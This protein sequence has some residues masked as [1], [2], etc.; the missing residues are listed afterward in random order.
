[1]NNKINIVLFGIGNVGSA[2]INK[3]LKNRKRLVL[4]KQIDF[5]FP[6]ITNSS[7]AF[8]AKEGTNFSWEANFIQF[9]IPFKMEDVMDYILVNNI[10]NVIAVDATADN[11]LIKEY[12]ALLQNGFSLVSV[13]KSLENLPAG[14]EGEISFAAAVYGQDYKFI[15][16]IKGDK[17]TAAQKL[18]ESLIEIAEKQKVL[19]L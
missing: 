17:H 14:L 2:L 9:G 12:P 11:A 5:R 18:Y 19:A 15:E 4:D 16:N 7:V 13:N 3:V 6:V 1:M 8:F 10:S